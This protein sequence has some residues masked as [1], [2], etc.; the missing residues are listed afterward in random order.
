MIVTDGGQLIRCP[1]RN[2]S[3]VSRAARGV[4]VIRVKDTEKVVSVERIE[5][6]GEEDDADSDAA[7]VETGGDV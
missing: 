7:D 6:S 4:T 5:E 2:I 1:V 3:I